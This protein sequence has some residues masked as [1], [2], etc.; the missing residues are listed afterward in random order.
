MELPHWLWIIIQIVAGL[1]IVYVYYVISL[2]V[3]TT[4]NLSTNT[5]LTQAFKRETVILNGIIDATSH[6]KVVYNTL[7]PGGA[8]A[9]IDIR[10]SIN[11]MGGTQFTYSFWLYVEDMSAMYHRKTKFCYDATRG[12]MYPLF[13]KGSDQC[14]EYTRQFQD[15][16][17]EQFTGRWTMCPLVAIGDIK[18]K[19]LLIYFNTLEQIDN[20]ISI[21]KANLNWN[22]DTTRKN[23]PSIVEGRWVMYTFV[24]V[25]Y[26]PLDDFANGIVVKTY[27]NDTLYQMNK[28]PGTLKENTGNFTILPDGAPGSDTTNGKHT[29]LLMSSF[30]YFNYAMSDVEVLQRF[31]KGVS[32]KDNFDV[33]KKKF[34]KLNLSAYNKLD[35]YNV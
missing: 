15:Q 18:T 30:S 4:D 2:F 13:I 33:T 8:G 7:N 11:R 20:V 5:T 10:S 14:Y 6:K 28:V 27:V 25:D 26:V 19:E 29:N 32:E 16:K 21:R 1:V 12:D 22:D 9:Y 34:D 3:M 31:A 24:F 35:L 23:L 17:E